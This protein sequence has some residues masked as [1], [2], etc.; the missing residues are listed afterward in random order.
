MVACVCV[1]VRVCVWVSECLRERVSVCVCVREREERERER[2]KNRLAITQIA[3]S[4]TN[5]V[6]RQATNAKQSHKGF[7][8]LTM[9]K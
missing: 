7:S 4:R 8:G 6:L 1:S 3:H 9:E 2:G 5:K